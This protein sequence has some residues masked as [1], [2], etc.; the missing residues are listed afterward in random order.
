M[1][2]IEREGA[3]LYY[4]VQGSGPAVVFV[5]GSGGNALSWWQ[6]I[7]PFAARHRVVAFDH[8][9]FGRSTCP[10]EALDPRH[11][12]SDLEIDWNDSQCRMAFDPIEHFPHVHLFAR[13]ALAVKHS[14]LE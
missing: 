7:P 6:Q 9:G 14:D 3:T 13:A 12:A 5:H 11:F 8:R 10:P 1:P 4:E 2:T